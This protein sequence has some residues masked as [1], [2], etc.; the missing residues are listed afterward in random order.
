MPFSFQSRAKISDG[1]IFWASISGNFALAG[2]NQQGLLG[3]LRQGADQGFY[4]PLG[5]QLIHAPDGGDH[6]LFDLAFF[7]AVFDDLKVLVCARFIYSS[8][9]GSLQD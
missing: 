5:M 2:Y 8:K 9:H 3:E 4:A 1:P 7:F 6:A